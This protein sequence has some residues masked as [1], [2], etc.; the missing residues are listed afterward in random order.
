VQRFRTFGKL[1]ACV[2]IPAALGLT[3]LAAIPAISARNTKKRSEA[4]HGPEIPAKIEFLETKYRFET[5]GDSLKEVYARVKIHNELGVEQFAR[6]K[7]DYNRSF[8]SV[9][10]PLVR[11]IH[12]NG[13]TAEILPNAVLDNPDPA[14]LNYPAYR[15]VRVKSV[16]VLGLV[17]GDVL[18]YRVVTKT[19]HPPLAPDFWLAHSF[20]RSGVVHIEDFDLDLPASVKIEI[21]PRTPALSVERTG[22]GDSARVHYH[23]RRSDV[24]APDESDSVDTSKLDIALG[25]LAEWDKLS[26]RLA[27]ALYPA[28]SEAPAIQK[29]ELEL[30]QTAKSEEEKLRAIYGFVSQKIPTVDLPLGSTGYRTRPVQEI[31][32]SGYAIPEDK[33]AL[34]VALARA[35]RLNPRIYFTFAGTDTSPVALP[36]RFEH[37]LVSAAAGTK[38]IWLDPT[39]EVAPFGMVSGKFRDKRVFRVSPLLPEGNSSSVYLPRVPDDLPFHGM[40]KVEVNAQL[41]N[42]GTLSAKVKYTLRGD[43][44][45]LLRVA[46]HQNP[47]NKWKE[48]GQ[49]LALT[50]GFRGQVSSVWASD[51]YATQ[52]PFQVEYEIS[53]PKFVDWKKEPVRIPAILPLIT[54][55]DPAATSSSSHIELGTPLD[56]DLQVTLELPPQ[57]S[58]AAPAGV[59]VERDYASFVSKYTAK[60]ETISASRQLR[61]LMPELPADRAMDYGAFVRAVQTDEAQDFTL[62]R[63]EEKQAA[64]P[65]KH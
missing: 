11:I 16:R 57:T 17:P 8:Q 10:I 19:T 60:G 62:Q 44:E 58:A 49:L 1:S 37:L 24:A 15:D 48:L 27:S 29:E 42:H 32:A 59:S 47:K 5:N 2:S 64:K 26:A 63:R 34:F 55:P 25:T 56:V 14:V 38:R 23:W 46:F 12:R 31:L 13:G 22:Q 65:S 40:Q 3:L 53:Q 35:A 50:D 51:P 30:T 61:F 7:F 18:E 4:R 36:S 6:L 39:I 21:S 54:L 9:E 28:A 33:A 45:L 52:E 41:D 43:N 20:D